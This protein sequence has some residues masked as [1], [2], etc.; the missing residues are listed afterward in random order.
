MRDKTAGT[1]STTGGSSVPAYKNAGLN[2]S[3]DAGLRRPTSKSGWR[4]P[5]VEIEVADQGEGV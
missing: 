4:R 1:L 2:Y 5:P 3:N